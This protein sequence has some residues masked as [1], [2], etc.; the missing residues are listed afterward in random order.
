MYK[1]NP[2]KSLAGLIGVGADNWR[3]VE[4]STGNA[5]VPFGANYYDPHTGWAPKLW[6]QFDE[7]TVDKHFE[8]MASIHVNVARVFFTLQSFMPTR[9]TVSEEALAKFDKLI[10]LADKHHIKLLMSGPDFWEGQPSWYSGHLF[11][12]EYVMEAYEH[13]WRTIGEKYAGETAIFA[14][15]LYNEPQIGWG[16]DM[17]S[18]RKWRQWVKKKYV[19]LEK[20]KE[21]WGEA[22]ASVQDF[23]FV[24]VP[25]RS[26]KKDDGKLYDYQLFREQLAADWTARM[27]KAIRS[28]D[29]NHLVTIGLVN[30]IPFEDVA[31]PAIS[32][33]GFN[34]HKLRDYLDF[35]S[36]HYYPLKRDP[37]A[38]PGNMELELNRM[39]MW[40]RYGY[41]E[42]PIMIG[43][44]GW[45]GG[46]SVDTNEAVRSEEE[47]AAWGKALVEASIGNSA[48]WATWPVYD[49]P[50]ST[51]ISKFGGL[52]DKDGR[53]K[54]WG[55][56]FGQLAQSELLKPRIAGEQTVKLDMRSLYTDYDAQKAMFDQVM[57][58]LKRK[59][60]VDFEPVYN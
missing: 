42:Q 20:L 12:S 2:D 51:D 21:A 55:R 57:D 23:E 31:D 27:V 28:G 10:S 18:D 13:F 29:R 54:E 24:E 14:W 5:F 15:D 53:L 25:D 36:I 4:L 11:A 35:T 41:A 6:E 7:R 30:P 40:L 8:Q 39:M 32:F 43:E 56:T 60:R 47:Q 16:G 38:A 9:D 50:S 59:V 44:Y 46:G 45:Y 22:A 52:F 1:A 37:W 17:D 58:L 34:P 3:F 19:T 49:T 48:A 33:V 26:Y